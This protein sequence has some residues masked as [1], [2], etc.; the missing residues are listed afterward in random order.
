MNRFHLIPLYCLNKY[1]KFISSQADINTFKPIRRLY[2]NIRWRKGKTPHGVTA[3]FINKTKYEQVEDSK[4]YL[5]SE[6]M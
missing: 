4:L 3:S 2:Q 1:D 6:F 5:C